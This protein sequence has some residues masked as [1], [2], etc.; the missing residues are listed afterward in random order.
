MV[1]P[2]DFIEGV[3]V[4]ELEA[5]AINEKV[6]FTV[7]KEIVEEYGDDKETLLE[8][9][10]ER[11]DDLIPKHIIIDDYQIYS[12]HHIRISCCFGSRIV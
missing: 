7:L 3:T 1:D 10:K 9:M 12:K 6:R 2:L 11:C 4:E 8:V 5:I